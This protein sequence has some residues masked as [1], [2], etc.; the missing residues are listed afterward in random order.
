LVGTGAGRGHVRV[1]NT[2]FRLFAVGRIDLF[3]VWLVL[4]ALTRHLRV[5]GTVGRVD[6]LVVWLVLVALTRHVWVFRAVGVVS[7]GISILIARAD[8]VIRGTVG[9]I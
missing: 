2:Y 7:D 5:G 4:I 6:L 9:R 8:L 1:F 3:I